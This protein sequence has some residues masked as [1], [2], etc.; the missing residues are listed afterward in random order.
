VPPPFRAVIFDL[1]GVLADSEPWWNRIDAKLLGEYGVT[2]HGECHENMLGV[3]YR[4][5]VEFYKNA[6]NISVPVRE[7]TR[8]RGKIATG[9]FA[10]RVGL[11]PSAKTTLKEV[12]Q[13]K[14]RLAVATSSVS[15]SACPLLERTGI[16]GSFEVIVTGD[17]VQRGHIESPEPM[18]AFFVVEGGLI[19]LDKPTNG[20]FVAYEDGFTLL[21]LRRKH[22]RE[23]G[24]DAR[25]NSTLSCARSEICKLCVKRAPQTSLVSALVL[26]AQQIVAGQPVVR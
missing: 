5:A 9:Y 3:G 10:N 11:F 25:A 12:W 13:L 22:Y 6:F 2:Y 24:L 16:R 21:G 15:V 4:L 23:A 8:R 14:L 18:V 1:D 20:G 17:E 26:I 7:L 19:Y